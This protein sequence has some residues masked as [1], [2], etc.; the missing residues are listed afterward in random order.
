MLARY[1][2]GND[3]W[4][5]IMIVKNISD[6]RVL[7]FYSGKLRIVYIDGI[8]KMKQLDSWEIVQ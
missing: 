6:D 4:H 3:K 5:Y 8:E 2:W 7:V 1:R